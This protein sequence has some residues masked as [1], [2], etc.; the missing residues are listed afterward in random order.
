MV[1]NK[2]III[3]ITVAILLSIVSVA[4]TLSTAH[5]NAKDIPDVNT[6]KSQ[7]KVNPDQT[8]AEVGLTIVKTNSPTP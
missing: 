1:S 7:G 6:L 3:L 8:S 2:I 4:V 5:V